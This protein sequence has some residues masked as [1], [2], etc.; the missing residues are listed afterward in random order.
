M[1]FFGIDWAVFISLVLVS[2]LETMQ[3]ADLSRNLAR[4]VARTLEAARGRLT[5][6]VLAGPAATGPARSPPPISRTLKSL[7]SPSAIG[8]HVRD[9]SQP[10]IRSRAVARPGC[11]DTGDAGPE[12]GA[13]AQE[14]FRRQRA[15]AAYPV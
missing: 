5:P 2:V 13:P 7:I 1:A 9:V 3:C 10:V 14:H 4:S 15:I 12:E 11:G 6:T 8:D